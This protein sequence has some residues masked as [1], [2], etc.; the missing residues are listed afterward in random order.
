MD[1]LVVKEGGDRVQDQQVLATL[2][3]QEYENVV[4]QAEAAVAEL[5]AQSAQ[6][7]RD[8]LRFKHLS[9]DNVVEDIRAGRSVTYSLDEVESDLVLVR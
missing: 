7:G 4:A 5:T 6:A 9:S 2:A 3:L 1:C 8:H